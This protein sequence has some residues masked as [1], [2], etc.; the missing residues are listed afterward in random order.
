MNTFFSSHEE[1]IN[2][3]NLLN[4]IGLWTFHPKRRW[5][6]QYSKDYRRLSPG[7]SLSLSVTVYVFH[8]WRHILAH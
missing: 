6:G 8:V 5:H 1:Y 7:V 3:S 2:I 4:S